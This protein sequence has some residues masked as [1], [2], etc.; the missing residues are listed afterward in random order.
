[1]HVETSL[2]EKRHIHIARAARALVCVL[3]ISRE[4]IVYG[5][6]IV[7]SSISQLVAAYG[8]PSMIYEP[9]RAYMGYLGIGSMLIGFSIIVLGVLWKWGPWQRPLGISLLAVGFVLL[10]LVSIVLGGWLLTPLFILSFVF[11]VVAWGISIGKGWG[12][13]AIEIIMII[14]IL[15]SALGIG[16]NGVVYVPGVLGALYIFWYMGRTHV[17]KFFGAY[18]REI[19]LGGKVTILTLLLALLILVPITFLCVYPPAHRIADRKVTGTGISGP[20]YR[21][22]A[23]DMLSYSFQIDEGL[24]QPVVFVI[25]SFTDRLSIVTIQGYN[26]SDTTTVTFSDRFWVSIANPRGYYGDSVVEYEIIINS[27]SIQMN[28]LEWMLL[29]VYFVVTF[30]AIMLNRRARAQKY[31]PPPTPNKV[32]PKCGKVMW[33]NFKICPSCEEPLPD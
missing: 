27:F 3:P 31:A 10:G 9:L 11:F 12:K 23:G 13:T 7:G 25:E 16:N 5:L 28:A 15:L 26:G 29:D 24:W 4:V 18:P 32:C 14:G 8:R 21:F 19:E 22:S 1:M 20:G 6:A 17:A 2:G 33:L 30:S